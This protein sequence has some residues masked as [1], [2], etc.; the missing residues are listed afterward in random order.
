MSACEEDAGVVIAVVAIFVTVP[1]VA[2]VTA[3]SAKR[4]SNMNM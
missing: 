1:V 4:S 2:N 3:G